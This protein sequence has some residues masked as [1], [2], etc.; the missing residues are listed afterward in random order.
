MYVTVAA[1]GNH[2]HLLSAVKR[3]GK[4]VPTKGQAR[5]RLTRPAGRSGPFNPSRIESRQPN[6][7]SDRIGSDRSGADRIASHRIG[8]LRCLPTISVT[9]M[10]VGIES[11]ISDIFDIWMDSAAA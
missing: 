10:P 6:R 9:A 4:R 11:D 5:G 3:S 2:L 1:G 7:R 8:Y